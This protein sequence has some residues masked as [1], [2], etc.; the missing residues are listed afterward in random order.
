MKTGTLKLSLAA[1]GCLVAMAAQQAKADTITYS[2]NTGNSAISGYAGPYGTVLVNRTSST[3]ATI[4]F[5]G[6]LVAGNQYLFGGNGAAAVNVNAASWTL[7]PITASNSGTGFTPTGFAGVGSKSEDGFGVFNQV[8]S[9]TG[10]YGSTANILSF[11]L[12]DTAGTWATASDVLTE[13][14][15]H[16]FITTSP[17][18][19]ANGALVTGYAGNGTTT[20]VPDGG[21]TVALLG[22]AMLGLGSVRSAFKK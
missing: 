1:I 10:G 14:A 4:T 19:A 7:G 15:A 22:L 9:N 3:V 18:N 21:S 6:G 16:I 11:S 20:D 8:I 5:T 12:T 13:V 2:L 17:A